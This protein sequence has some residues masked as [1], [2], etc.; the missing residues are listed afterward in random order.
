[1][2]R[3]SSP[4]RIRPWRRLLTLAACGLLVSCGKDPRDYTTF[5]DL[6]EKLPLAEIRREPELVDLGSPAVRPSLRGGWSWDET[7]ADGKTLVWSDGPES[8]LDFFLT[9]PRDLTVLFRGAPYFFRDEPAQQVIFVV[10]GGEA[11]TVTMKRGFNE[12]SIVLPERILKTGVNRLTLRYGY[13]RRPRDV[14][15]GQLPDTR[16]LGVH[17]DWLRFGTGVDPE[18]EV[19]ARGNQLYIPFGVRIDFYTRFPASGALTFERLSDRGIGEGRLQVAVQPEGKEGEI[20]APVPPRQEPAA[21]GL[22]VE[23]GRPVRVSLSAVPAKRPIGSAS[24]VVL[25]RPAFGSAGAAPSAPQGTVAQAAARKEARP[26]NV[27][28]YMVDTLRADHLGCYGYDKPVSPHLD[29]FAREAVLFENA[30]AQSPWTR[31]SVASMLTGLWPKTHGVNGRNDALSPEALTLPEMLA[32]RG[33]RS[34]GI[35]TNGNVAKAFGFAQGFDVYEM[36]ARQDSAHVNERARAFLDANA[37]YPFFLY[38]HTVDPHSPYKPSPEYRRRFAPGVPQEGIGTRKWLRRLH[39]RRLR[40]TPQI[41]DHLTALYDAEIAS[42]DASFGALIADLK[43]RGLWDETIVIFVSDHGEE[44]HDHGGWE[45][46]KT[47]YAEMIHVP[48]LIRIPGMGEGRRVSSLAQHIDLV[49]TLLSALGLPLPGHLE[50]RDLLPIFQGSRETAEERPVYSYM[51]VD[52]HR[53]ASAVTSDWHLIDVRGP[54]P[55]AHLYERRRDPKERDNQAAKNPVGFGYLHAL[56]AARELEERRILK[57]GEGVID[58]DLREQL[59][60]LGYIH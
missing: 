60:A 1:M 39:E 32:S 40:V 34:A 29:A 7:G 41:V 5:Y 17:W 53:G 24:G 43:H 23:T 38:L 14:T 4:S 2:S 13:T 57:P 9:E 48:L 50:G 33:Y 36:P 54:S 26:W 15:S 25:V 51:D 6:V 49:P 42:N 16:R 20:L 30:F 27:V 59:R 35:T 28:F 47:L 19:R 56:L 3:R 12:Y 10:N 44:F 55:S 21:I 11:G 18:S 45:H 37:G 58:E 46:G 31:P 22:R 8:A 52:G